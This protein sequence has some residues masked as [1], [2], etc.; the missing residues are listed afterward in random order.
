MKNKIYFGFVFL[1][2]GISVSAR[3][4]QERVV[5]LTPEAWDVVYGNANFEESGVTIRSDT[6]VLLLDKVSERCPMKDFKATVVM[7]TEQQLK[8]TGARPW[9]VG[10]IFF[11][12]RPDGLFKKTNYF[13]SK[14]VGNELGT[15]FDEYGQAFLY[16]DQTPR[17]EIG[18]SSLY[19]IEKVGGAVKV[20]IEGQP[21]LHYKSNGLANDLYD[22]GGSF[23]LYAEV[24]RVKI[25]S[26][27]LES[28]DDP[29]SECR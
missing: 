5:P 9:E 28:L 16:T 7:K 17:M 21:V 20:T 2:L 24:S 4:G 18:K 8:T 15:A 22:Q 27:T 6:G 26:V 25:T 1:L 29:H 3:A 19:V 11:N 14:P 13:V 12:Y 10:W 23:G